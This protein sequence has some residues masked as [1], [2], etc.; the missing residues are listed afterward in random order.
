MSLYPF[1]IHSKETR[2]VVALLLPVP[3]PYSSSLRAPSESGST[4]YRCHTRSGPRTWSSRRISLMTGSY[5]SSAIFIH[6]RSPTVQDPETGVP[7]SPG[8]DEADAE[9][10]TDQKVKRMRFNRIECD[11][12]QSPGFYSLPG[13]LSC[14]SQSSDFES[15][16]LSLETSTRILIRIEKNI[17][18]ESS[19][20]L[21]DGIVVLNFS[22]SR[23]R[24]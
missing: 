4:K 2:W 19:L 8:P 22:I 6:T 20:Q 14:P 21:Y 13:C 16:V 3:D 5:R 18:Q 1:F 10:I 7:Q 11:C 17:L 12:Y 23:V 15:G 24:K 9:P